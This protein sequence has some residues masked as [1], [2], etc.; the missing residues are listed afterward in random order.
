MEIP[1]GHQVVM[2][3]LMVKGA[4]KFIDFAKKVFEAKLTTN[5][6]KLREDKTTVMHSE[7]TIGGSVIMFSDATEQ[8]PVQT[9]NL[10]VYV[11]N[12]D[13]TY[14][15]AIESGATTVIELSNQDY[16]RSCGVTD[17]LGNVWWITS[18]NKR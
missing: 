15:K 11:D 7:I 6:H 3:Y 10:F 4:S 9:A 5:M 14:K 2:P 1:K 18:V 13:A 17:P 12:A 16:G 8:W